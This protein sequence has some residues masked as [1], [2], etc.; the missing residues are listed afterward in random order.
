MP[1]T[2]NKNKT[3]FLWIESIFLFLIRMHTKKELTNKTPINIHLIRL[4]GI[5]KHTNKKAK[6]EYKQIYNLFLSI[7]IFPPYY[8]YLYFYSYPSVDSVGVVGVV[9]VDDAL[10]E[11]VNLC[12]AK[13]SSSVSL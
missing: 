13:L 7:L 12:S 11:T 5:N 4:V 3:S 2:L 1:I 10:N 8:L 6:R 9:S